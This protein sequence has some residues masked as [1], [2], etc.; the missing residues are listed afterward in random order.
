[1]SV[2]KISFKSLF[3]KK[4]WM[5]ILG[6]FLFVL[7]LLIYTFFSGNSFE[8]A[9]PKQI[10]ISR[11]ESLNKIANTLYEAKIIP[12]K[13]NFKVAAFLYAAEKRIQAGR[14]EIPSG[15]SYFDILDKFISGD[16]YLLKSV[17]I[18]DGITIT[19][20]KNKLE[21]TVSVDPLKFAALITDKDFL[22]KIGFKGNS[23]E[24]YLLPGDY[25]IYEKSS[26]EETVEA[27]YKSY[28]RFFND[29]LKNRAAK[30]GYSVHQ[31]LTMASI[32]Q[33]ETRNESEMP[34]IAGVY[35]N[36]LKTGMRLQADP[37]VQYLQ[38]KGWKRLSFNDLKADSPYNTYRYKGLPPG[39]INNPGKKAIMASLYPKSHDYLFFVANGKGT[40]KFSRNFSD[41]L[42]SANEYRKKLDSKN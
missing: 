12:S 5:V 26:A 14:Y 20:I 35:Y 30:L 19:G 23:L 40:H 34:V 3:T 27:M 18:Y 21:K 39:P 41:H 13:F 6:V 16:G 1:M 36:R 17:D 29:S 28:K 33:G 4:Q 42:A 9:S 7:L 10:Q 25:E 22:K 24:G 8:G 11:G 15:L 32:V 37:T 38:D 2:E 31:I